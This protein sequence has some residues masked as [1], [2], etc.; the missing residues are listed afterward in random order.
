MLEPA[1]QDPTQ[2]GAIAVLQVL[3]QSTNPQGTK[4]QG[5]PAGASVPPTR[6]HRALSGTP[7]VGSPSLLLMRR[8]PDYKV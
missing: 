7:G 5:H 3:S 2:V 1:H 8:T 4:P 6:S